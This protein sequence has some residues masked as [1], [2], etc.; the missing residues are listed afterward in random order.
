[1]INTFNSNIATQYS[2]N[3]AIFIQQLAQWIFVNL[4][5]NRHIHDGLCWSYNSQKAFQSIFPYWTRQNLRTIINQAIKDGLVIKGNYNKS[6]Y[7]RT[8]W[9]ALTEKGLSH[10][11]E[12][13]K[14]FEENIVSETQA[15]S[16]LSETKN[17][18][19][20]AQ[21]DWLASTNRFARSNPP[22]P[23][24]NSTNKKHIYKYICKK[25]KEA[26]PSKPIEP[27]KPN[28]A[29]NEAMDMMLSNNP[30]EIDK[31]VLADWVLVRKQK[32]AVITKTAWNRVLK[33]LEKCKQNG[34][35]T[36]DCFE[37]AVG[38]GWQSL[39]M[40]W[41]INQDKSQQGRINARNNNFQRMM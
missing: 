32:K 29:D 17:E 28:K 25:E 30:F 33:E 4:A 20:Q 7:D 23:T 24:N 13:V 12:L 9:Y 35:D 3:T 10:Y 18:E 21:T 2:V 11:P 15:Q 16:G 6:L 19:T 31:E 8:S 5:N 34:L 39:K 22:I 41:F 36:K 40:E 27:S 26:V 38:S 1:M 14:L 37:K